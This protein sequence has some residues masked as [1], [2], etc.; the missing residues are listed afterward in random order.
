MGQA[1]NISAS[2]DMGEVLKNRLLPFPVETTA[3]ERGSFGPGEPPQAGP[4][5]SLGG[6]SQE[7]CCGG[8]GGRTPVSRRLCA[9]LA[10]LLEQGS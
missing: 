10:F 5:W 2:G 7:P 6:R 8:Q 9:G 1:G 4:A 3:L